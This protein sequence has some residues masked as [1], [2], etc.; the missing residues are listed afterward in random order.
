MKQRVHK[1]HPRPNSTAAGLRFIILTVLLTAAVILFPMVQASLTSPPS[2]TSSA[3]EKS[4]QNI[5]HP[6]ETKKPVTQPEA[7]ADIKDETVLYFVTLSEPSLAETFLSLSDGTYADCRELLLS[8]AGR[9]YSDAVKRSQAVAKA[10]ITKLVPSSDF[11][12]GRVYSALWNAL[13]FE[14]PLSVK[15][16]IAS[17]NGVSEVYVLSDDWY[18]L[19]EPSAES[20]G[21]EPPT[22]E[23]ISRTE[24]DHLPEGEDALDEKG[25]SDAEETTVRYAQA[26]ALQTA[27]HQQIGDTSVTDADLRGQG[28]LIAVLDSEF[29]V[30][31][32]VFSQPPTVSRWNR[33]GLTALSQA[34]RFHVDEEHTGA[35]AY[36]S[37]KIAFAYDYAENDFDTADTSLYHGTL[38]AAI[39][40]GHNGQEGINAYRGLAPDAQLALMKIASARM[41]DG[42]ILIKTDA[43]LSALD[44]AVKLGADV[45]NASFGSESVS[46]NQSLYQQAF[47]RLK[48]IGIAVW[49]AAGN[50]GYN[51]QA[52]GQSLTVHDIFYDTE[53]TLS[54]MDGVTAVGSMQNALRVR[55]LITIGNN[56]LYYHTLSGVPLT[57]VIRY[58]EAEPAPTKTDDTSVNSTS[59]SEVSLQETQNS[60]PSDPAVSEDTN[61]PETASEPPEDTLSV[62]DDA[63][64]GSTAEEPLPLVQYNE[65]IYL[66]QCDR[67]T[68]LY[69]SE[70]SGKLLML[71]AA[72]TSDLPSVLQKAL[73]RGVSAIALIGTEEI[74]DAPDQ[75][76]PF[77]FIENSDISWLEKQPKGRY[78]MVLE[79]ETAVPTQPVGVSGFTSYGSVHPYSS[80]SR[81]MLPG[82]D[83]YTGVQDNARAFL[84]GTS[85]AAAGM[86]GAYAAVRQA[87]S[88]DENMDTYSSA[89]KAAIARSLLLS[90]AEPLLLTTQ[91]VP[92]YAS[93]RVQGFGQ[94]RLTKA[95]QTKAYLTTDTDDLQAVTLSMDD[96]GVCRFRFSLH[97]LSERA[98]NYIPSL[99]LQTD[100][101]E[102]GINLLQPRSLT[103]ETEVQFTVDSS[104]KQMVSVN[105]HSSTD[106]DVTLRMNPLMRETLREQFPAGCYW[107][108]YIFLT[109][110]DGSGRLSLP[111]TGFDGDAATLSPFDHTRY[112]E[113][114]SLSGLDNSFAAVADK[115][116]IC[117]FGTLLSQQDEL[118]Y[119]PDALRTLVDDNSFGTALILPDSY[120]LQDWYDCTLTLYDTAGKTL[121]TEN[122]GVISSYRAKGTRP[123]EK[124]LTQRNA[125]AVARLTDAF[126]KLTDGAS[127][128][129][130]LSARTLLPD[131]TLSGTFRTSSRFR[132][133]HTV[134]TVLSAET[135]QQDDRTILSLTARD[136]HGIQGFALYACTYDA[137]KNHYDYIDSLDTMIQAGYMDEEAYQFIRQQTNEDGSQ[138]F[139]YDVTNLQTA[140]R[141]LSINTEAWSVACSDEQIAIKAL[142]NACNASAVRIVDAIAFGR[143]AFRFT[144]Q[145]GNPAKGI[146]VTIG[147]DTVTSDKDGTACFEHLAP[148]YYHAVLS[149]STEDYTIG[150]THY[151]VAILPDRL[152]YRREQSVTALKPYEP[153]PPSEEAVLTPSQPS[154]D[155]T[156]STDTEPADDPLY[157]FFFVGTFFAI[158]VILFL[159]HKIRAN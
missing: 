83:V 97:N 85:A 119:S 47:R 11:Q 75:H 3:V 157:A 40:A 102:E 155:S 62:P 77:L 82:E 126:Q 18:C 81:I 9:S 129:Y 21:T 48:Q 138:T 158:C 133:D 115:T 99:V 7:A 24:K 86:T 36:V 10:S 28:T 87:L 14:A 118:L 46:Q 139:L 32:P 112:E 72:Q 58:T 35:D 49:A 29:D 104:D 12:N 142:D 79:D 145:N 151:L 95:L 33:E 114:S 94:L 2:N 93:P 124:W 60:V 22:D 26:Q 100:A 106:I 101:C 154:E 98:R 37:P 88:A 107:D 17:L 31:D 80:V 76:I 65:Y 43:L 120:P 141:K 4:K 45:I 57:D 66:D 27:Y 113:E 109:P 64:T 44:D 63:D 149:Y 71:N 137:K 123:L 84:N 148:N 16:K 111:L 55:H 38:T 140:L 8:K 19:D 117:R 92:L 67:S 121:C 69:A 34:A 56:K 116:G 156:S 150:N 23:E 5:V 41:Y 127:Y 59:G 146:R 132:V 96:S 125:S 131:G 135:K 130:E 90:T 103:G 42:R 136:A 61:K 122:F 144:D 70:L 30:T 50:S 1:D 13:T 15:D 52:L 108:G 153:E 39:A 74:P 73:S 54:S 51:G 143:A 152:E 91:G 105:A 53:N 89:K 159:H 68:V 78:E 110:T 147:T 20:I 6:Q 25:M 134:P 128:R